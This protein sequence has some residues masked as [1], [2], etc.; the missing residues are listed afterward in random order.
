MRLHFPIPFLLRAA[1]DNTRVAF[2]TVDR[3]LRASELL[4][5]ALVVHASIPLIRAA[6]RDRVRPAGGTECTDCGRAPRRT[7]ACSRPG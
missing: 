1:A 4:T 7:G 3:S 6:L 5:K 2:S